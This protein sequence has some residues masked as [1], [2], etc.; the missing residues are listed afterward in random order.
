MEI[1]SLLLG[2]GF[3]KRIATR[4]PKL[5]RKFR[6]GGHEDEKRPEERIPLKV[7]NILTPQARIAMKFGE[8]VNIRLVKDGSVRETKCGGE[9]IT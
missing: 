9:K 5:L 4:E 1:N 6:L 3:N 8:E 7:W 2:S